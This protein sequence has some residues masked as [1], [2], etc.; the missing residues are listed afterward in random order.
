MKFDGKN[1]TSY[2]DAGVIDG[3]RIQDLLIDY[4]I[5]IIFFIGARSIKRA[6]P[7]N[8]VRKAV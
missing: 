4:L 7:E 3:K 5:D 6:I 8:G 2:E 1:W